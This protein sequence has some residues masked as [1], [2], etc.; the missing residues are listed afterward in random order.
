MKNE[1]KGERI[2]LEFSHHPGCLS[3]SRGLGLR[4]TRVGR[5]AVSDIHN[6]TEA[7][8]ILAAAAMFRKRAH[9]KKETTVGN[10]SK[11]CVRL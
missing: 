6:L 5:T 10:G 3:C 11:Q 9:G 2:T 4:I 1:K 8:G 7:K